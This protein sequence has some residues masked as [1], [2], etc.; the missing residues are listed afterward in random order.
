MK[1]MIVAVTTV[2][3]MSEFAPANAQFFAGPGFHGGFGYRGGHRFGVTIGGPGLRVG[4][5]TSGYYARSVVVTPPVFGWGP[6]FGDPF[7]LAP[8]PP[9]FVVPPPI[10]FAGGNVEPE[11]PPPARNV[12]QPPLRKLSD[13]VVFRPQKDAPPDMGV[14]TPMVERVAPRPAPPAFRFDPFAQIDQGK[15]ERPDPDPA[16]E[17]ARQ[18]KMARAA[19]AAEE[20]G[21]AVERL[22]AA[23]KARPDDA[24]PHFLKAQ[25][26]FAAGQ[27]GEAVTSIREGMK[28]APDWPAAAFRPKEL[29]GANA[30]RFDAHVADLRLAAEANPAE[31]GLAFLL[32][33]QLWFTGDRPAATKLFRAAA[34]RVKDATTIERFLRVPEKP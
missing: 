2:L 16:T 32:G 10:V 31:P 25:V 27:Y 12:A 22:D 5:F 19:F 14:L 24:L 11:E 1:G 6:G 30:A 15:I 4:A 28:L 33:Y 17:S 23:S 21:K 13:F 9:V 8:P 20:Y 34:P 29:Y 7:L 3:G 18:M 26:R